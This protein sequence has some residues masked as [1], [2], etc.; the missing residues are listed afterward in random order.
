V[1]VS[2]V[3]PAGLTLVAGSSSASCKQTGQTVSCSVGTLAQGSTT[4]LT[5]VVQPGTSSQTYSLTFA[6]SS[7]NGDLNPGDGSDAIALYWPGTATGSDGPLP[8]WAVIALGMGLVGVAQ[9]QLK[10]VA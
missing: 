4:A 6:A 10:N 8:L 2:T 5:I 1:V 3:L 9:R 7:S